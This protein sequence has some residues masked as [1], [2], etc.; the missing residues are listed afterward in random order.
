MNRPRALCL[1][2]AIKAAGRIV[3]QDIYLVGIDATP[4]AIDAI[5]A[6]DMTGTVLHDHI[7]QAHA[8]VDAAI[9]YVNGQRVE[10]YIWIDYVP[11]G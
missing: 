3:G 6:G 1:I 5:N 2:Q 10:T 7:S 4:E 9:R 11:V 8:A